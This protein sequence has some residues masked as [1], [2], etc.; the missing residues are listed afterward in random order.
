MP[1]LRDSSLAP[2]DHVECVTQ[3]KQ[4]MSELSGLA[5]EKNLLL[6]DSCWS[7]LIASLHHVLEQC[8]SAAEGSKST[9]Q[10]V[11]SLAN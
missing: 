11:G 6:L 10:E 7:D 8:A 5:Q 3:L 2:C 9:V 1:I 4:F